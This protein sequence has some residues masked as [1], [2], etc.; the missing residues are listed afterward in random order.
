MRR[1][2]AIFPLV[3]V[4]GAALSGCSQNEHG[5]KVIA[6]QCIADGG[7]EDVCDCLAKTTA[8]RLDPELFDMVVLGAQGEDL[9]AARIMEE[10]PP[11]LEAK[12]ILTIPDIKRSCGVEEEPAS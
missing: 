11:E 4:A 7:M 6:A 2:S 10:L 9:E 3:A 8:E 12:F 1:L 5:K